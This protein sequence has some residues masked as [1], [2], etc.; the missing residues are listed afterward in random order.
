MS[1]F[2]LNQNEIR[3]FLKNSDKS[4]PTVLLDFDGVLCVQ[5]FYREREAIEDLM[6]SISLRSRRLAGSCFKLTE[7]LIETSLIEPWIWA[8]IDDIKTLLSSDVPGRDILALNK[9]SCLILSDKGFILDVFSKFN[10]VWFTQ[11]DRASTRALE[12]ALNIE[13]STWFLTTEQWS[14]DWE[15]WF[16][17]VKAL[18]LQKILDTFPDFRPDL[19]IDDC[20][21]GFPGALELAEKFFIKA[22]APDDR[23]GLLPSTSRELE[24]LMTGIAVQS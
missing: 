17:E 20:L 4:K 23:A 2:D 24:V 5:D 21:S 6:S 12:K 13:E 7:E 19:W 1:V 8:D 16:M 9:D 15:D 22:V 18:P 10:I 14:G 3:D 11:R